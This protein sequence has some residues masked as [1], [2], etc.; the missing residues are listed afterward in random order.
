M[1]RVLSLFAGSGWGVAC[2]RLGW[3]ED[4]VDNDAAVRQTRTVAGMT[5]VG[6]DVRDVQA[7]PVQY[8]GHIAS[9]SCK[10]YTATG[11]GAG[12]RAIA[13]V[14]HGVDLYRSRRSPTSR[15]LA[16]LV[17]DADAALTL[18]PLRIALTGRPRFLVWE[19]VPSVL[20]IWQACADVLERRGYSTAVGVLRAE[21]FGVPQV[22]RRA[23]LVARRDGVLA[24]LPKPTHSRFYQRVPER[25]DAGVTRWVGMAETLGWD[26]GCMVVSN[27]SN[28]GDP[29]SR[30][31]RPAV[32]PAVT[33]TSKA[34]RMR[35]VEPRPGGQT[36]KRRLRDE[37]AAVLQTYPRGFEFCGTKNA[38]SEQI[39]NAVPPRLALVLLRGFEQVNAV[40]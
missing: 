19:Q 20:P 3:E 37:E 7:A 16:E 29:A 38:R 11:N 22:R 26:P 35:V 24:R 15:Q 17:G 36:Y 32:H 31:V 6:S 21:Q 23:F 1:T 13:A 5:N 8:D 2:K 28:N 18:E 27:Y 25:V 9:P 14:L 39:G 12:R 10:R 4:G 34:D 40:S 30:G 33:I